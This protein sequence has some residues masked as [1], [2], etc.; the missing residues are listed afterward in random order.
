M[1]K[2]G[3][4]E[5]RNQR[6]VSIL[7]LGT[8]LLVGGTLGYMLIEGWTLAES[9]FMTV[10]TLSTVG[11]GE[12]QPLTPVGQVFSIILIMFGV[13]TVA[14][15]FSTVADYIV[16]GELY[17]VLRRQRMI[18]EIGKLRNHYII[19]GYG[20]VGRQ[21]AEGLRNDGY[22][23]VVI[24][25]DPE[26]IRPLEEDLINHILGDAAEDRMLQEAGIE[27]ARGL[28]TCLRD[29]ADNVLVTLSART[30]NPSIFI[31]ARSNS[32]STEQKLHIAGANQVINPYSIAGNRMAAQM[33]HPGV[34][35]F[36]DVVMRRKD[37]ELH[38][39]EVVVGEESDLNGKA[40]A[41]SRVRSET[42]VNVLAIRR[43]DDR[44]FTDVGP[45]FLLRTGDALICLGTPQ[46][47]ADLAD[48]ASDQGKWSHFVRGITGA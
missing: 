21:V 40:L 37:L 39:E 28:F 11:Y 13:G 30:L 31:I 34:M 24:E 6:I 12:V 3:F 1:L 43:P 18:R 19:C 33:T 22:E 38:I 15:S 46:Q 9:L 4:R 36:L 20:R 17:G 48:L 42:G 5:Q 16:A 26:Q 8:S 27:H 2:D 35:E 32:A 44:L 45:D 25:N 29:D 41:D 23:I 14:Y 10:I 7:I 47:L